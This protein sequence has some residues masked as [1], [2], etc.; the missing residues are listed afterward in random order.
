VPPSEPPQDR[1]DASGPPLG[2]APGRPTRAERRARLRRQ[3]LLALLVAAGTFVVVLVLLFTVGPFGSHLGRPGAPPLGYLIKPQGGRRYRVSAWT[4]GDAGSLEAAAAA[5]AVDEVDFDWYHTQADGGVTAEREDP[6]LVGAARGYG[7]NLFATVT[8]STSANGA[9]SG[10]VAAAV[11]A[12]PDRRH[13][14]IDDLLALV[15]HM[16][17]DGVDLDWEGLKPADR[18]PFSALVEELAAALHVEHRF[19]AIAVVPKI[20]E[21]GQWASQRY[22]D[23]SSLGKAVDEFKIMTYSYSGPWGPPG[24]QAPLA[25]VDRVLSFA[26]RTMPAQK[27]SMGVPFFGFDWYGS[28]CAVVSAHR[29]A[30]FAATYHAA[31]GRDP[32][33]REATMTFI[34]GG[35][36]HHVYFQDGTALAAKLAELRARHSRIAGISTWVMGEEAPGFWPLIT[37]GLR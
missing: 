5:R 27:V 23:W 20:S 8:N 31:V 35:V 7:L 33:S 9:F 18:A 24:P 32:S 34:A 15:K 36:T 21:P 6:A 14:F 13:R 25:W 16:G 29:G 3:R 37:G 4:L 10:D 17:Y 2:S 19:L 11:L 22:A 30:S 28:S 12:S 26:Q 1:E